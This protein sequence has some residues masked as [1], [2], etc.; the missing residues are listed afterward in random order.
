MGGIWGGFGGSVRDAH[1]VG[2]AKKGGGLG[3]GLLSFCK[4]FVYLSIFFH[5]RCLLWIFNKLLKLS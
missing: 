4:S 5:I 1:N 3:G 2:M